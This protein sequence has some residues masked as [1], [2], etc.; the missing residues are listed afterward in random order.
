MSGGEDPASSQ[1]GAGDQARAD[2]VPHDVD[3]RIAHVDQPVDPPDDG[4]DL[5]RQVERLLG[6][7]LRLGAFSVLN[8]PVDMNQMLTVFRRLID[9]QYHGSWPPRNN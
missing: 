4:R 6:E 1:H 5:Q 8:K 7:A 9:R 3:G 2:E